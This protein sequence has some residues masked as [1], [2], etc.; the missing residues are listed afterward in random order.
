MKLDRSPFERGMVVP[1]SSDLDEVTRGLA[2]HK[3]LIDSK[4]EPDPTFFGLDM[5]VSYDPDGCWATIISS[6]PAIIYTRM[7]HG[8]PIGMA[9]LLPA[10][11]SCKITFL[12]GLAWSVENRVAA[13]WLRLAAVAHRAQF[14]NNTLVFI[15]NTA[16]EADLLAGF[17]ELAVCSC[18][19]S[20]IDL[21]LFRPL[22]GVSV[23]YDAIYNARLLPL[24]RHDL[25]L[26]ID[27]C[28]FIYYRAIE[29]AEMENAIIDRHKALA[30]NH[31]F[32]NT[33][34]DGKPI[35]MDAD[36]INI[37]L[38]QAGAGLCLSAEEGAMFASIEYLLAGL[39][40]VSTPSVGGRDG[41]YNEDYCLIAE[42]K[43][44][45]IS[46]AVSVIKE[47]QIS[48]EYIRN[49]TLDIINVHRIKF[50]D[51]IDY[52]KSGGIAAETQ[53]NF[54]SKIGTYLPW[55]EHW[56]QIRSLR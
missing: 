56:R 22:E 46:E 34:I 45:K 4:L 47:R 36:E 42:P 32:L 16:A 40:I 5:N 33:R 12:I 2:Q 24:K 23:D 3:S 53:W 28:A 21:D 18:R 9:G 55:E 15:T 49:K 29:T 52:L 31:R 50:L 43:P 13:E 39:P 51:V 30:P 20:T 7:D 41:Y 19:A 14:P 26:Q 6:S 35:P 25:T 27:K 54:P 48:R 10:D 17:G 37:A 44:E 11:I 8:L 38:N 1:R